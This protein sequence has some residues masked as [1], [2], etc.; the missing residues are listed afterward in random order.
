MR[1]ISG[2]F[3]RQDFR[4]DQTWGHCLFYTTPYILLASLRR[5]LRRDPAGQLV[6]L[7]D[8]TD[9]GAL[10][11]GGGRR[12][13]PLLAPADR[14][15]KA[16]VRVVNAVAARLGLVNTKTGV[17]IG[18]VAVRGSAGTTTPAAPA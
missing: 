17:L 14:L 5:A 3:E 8:D 1:K 6:A 15:F 18:I 11:P 2:F 10:L 16:G 7:V 4:I 12:R 13:R 9:A